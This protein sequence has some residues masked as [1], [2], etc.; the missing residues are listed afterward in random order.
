[1]FARASSAS[2]L[3]VATIALLGMQSQRCAAPP[4]D[5]ALD[6]R[7]LGAERRRDRRRGVARR[8]ATDDHE[9]HGH[10]VQATRRHPPTL[11]TVQELRTDELTGDARD[12]RARPRHRGPRCSARRPASGAAATPPDSCP[13]CAGH[14]A[15][16]PPEVA[17]VGAG[18]PDTPGWQVRVVP[19]LYPIVG[20]GV[21]GAHEVIVLS[22]AHD[23][24]LDALAARRRDR[25]ARRRCATAPRTTSMPASCTR[26]RS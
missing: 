8:A 13:F 11:T 21:P 7:D 4:I 1:M 22:P 18:A 3:P 24:Q 14:E 6:Q 23:R 20:D 26:S 5:V 12:R 15:M 2:S 10:D 19:N 9:T 25:G 16:T 17:R